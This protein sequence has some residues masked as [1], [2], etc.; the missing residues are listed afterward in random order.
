MVA[1]GKTQQRAG[2]GAQASSTG[3][4]SQLLQLFPRTA[5]QQ[6]VVATRVERHARGFRC[7]ASSWRCLSRG[8]QGRI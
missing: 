5:F 1:G 7:W 4:F 8:G 3:I 2:I 6:A